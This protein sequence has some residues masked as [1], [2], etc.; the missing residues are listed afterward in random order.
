MCNL[1]T[2][3]QYMKTRIF[4]VLIFVLL[5]SQALFAEITAEVDIQEDQASVSITIGGNGKKPQNK[6]IQ[7]LP[8]K[9]RTMQLGMNIDDVKKALANDSIFGY[10]GERDVSLLPSPNRVLIETSGLSF[11]DRSWFQFY[12]DK[13]YTMIFKLDED[14]VDFYSMFKTLNEKYG[15]PT[16]LSPDKV[17]W[18]DDSIT[19][20]LERPLTIKY[21]DTKVF[22]EIQDKAGIEKNKEEVTR[23]GFLDS[24]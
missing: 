12:E 15:E 13:L 16:S 2:D 9:Y 24:L 19:L 21:I 18:K 17:V 6:E 10:R 1:F 14:R 20:C 5:I 8:R 22:K 7:P 4:F 23:Q 3:K 11:L